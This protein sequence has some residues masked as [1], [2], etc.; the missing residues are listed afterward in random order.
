MQRSSPRL[1]AGPSLPKRLGLLAALIGLRA[2]ALTLAAVTLAI[3]ATM[4]I[5]LFGALLSP[6]LRY[7]SIVIAALSLPLPTGS[8]LDDSVFTDALIPVTG[9]AVALAA[10]SFGYARAIEDPKA[11]STA[12]FAGRL[13]LGSTVIFAL[14]VIRHFLEANVEPPV[15]PPQVL[16]HFALFADWCLAYAIA[17]AVV[18]GIAAVVVLY[19]HL[20]PFLLDHL[21]VLKAFRVAKGIWRQ[22]LGRLGP[23]GTNREQREADSA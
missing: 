22:S 12:L 7:L 17:V 4:V 16:Y 2:L 14:A 23:T 15:L 6:L 5:S 11:R 21:R 3:A 9:A 1:S 13:L 19:L 10:L 20:A 8:P 18:A